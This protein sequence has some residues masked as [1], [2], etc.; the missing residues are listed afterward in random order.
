MYPMPLL[1]R[2]LSLET[3]AF[4]TH[5]YEHRINKEYAISKGIYVPC[6]PDYGTDSVAE[7]AFIGLLHLYEKN[8]KKKTEG[9]GRTDIA[10]CIK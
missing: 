8:V 7:L 4:W 3:V 10:A 2:I 5:A 1:M 6:I 9:N